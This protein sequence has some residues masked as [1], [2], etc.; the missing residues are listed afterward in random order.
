MMM[1]PAAQT[2]PYYLQLPIF[3]GFWGVLGDFDLEAIRDATG[4]DDTL[5]AW[6]AQLLLPLLLPLL[7]ILSDLSLLVNKNN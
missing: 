1:Q 6:L 2:N 7:P 4:V 3:V 5:G